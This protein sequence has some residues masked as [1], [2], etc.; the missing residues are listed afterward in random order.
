MAPKQI[1]TEVLSL[2]GLG[3]EKGRSKGKLRATLTIGKWVHPQ[4]T[5]SAYLEYIPLLHLRGAIIICHTDNIANALSLNLALAAA[6]S[7]RYTP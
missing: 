6:F 4:H 3:C 7:E 1:T 5:S 2:E